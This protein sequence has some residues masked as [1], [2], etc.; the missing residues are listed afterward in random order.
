MRALVYDRTQG[1]LSHIWSNGSVL[2]R[3]LGRLD[4]VRGVTT[5]D[6]A[7]DWLGSLPE[8]I[9]ELQYWGHGLWGSAQVDRSTLDASSLL[10][11]RRELEAVRERLAPGALIWFRTCQTFGAKR[12][13][14]FAERYA[15]FF[16]ARVA[17]HTHVI[18]FH[19]SG[20]HGL[21]PGERAHWSTAEGVREGSA[22]LPLRARHSAPWRPRTI[23]AL[24]GRVPEAWFDSSHRL[25]DDATQDLE[26]KT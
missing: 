5:W 13:Q 24:R 2:Y 11:R 6:E 21:R 26:P 25:Q 7:L 18:G 10:S 12:G 9:S 15:D 3:G 19:Q 17:G 14:D 23:T 1:A 16:G 22:E 8:S 20:L 4:A